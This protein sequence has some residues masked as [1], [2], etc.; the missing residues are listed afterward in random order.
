[1]DA[2]LGLVLDALERLG[3]AENTIVV[4]WGDHGWLLG[5]H[6]CWQKMHLFEEAAQV[7]L[8]IYAP[9]QKA[10]GQETGRVAE[11]LDVYPTLSD[12]CGLKAPKTVQG[13][14]L[15][16]LLDDPNASFK[17]G[18]Y[19]QVLRGD[20]RNLA[21]TAMGRSV[22]TERWRYNEWGVGARYGSELYDHDADPREHKNLANLPGYANVIAEMKAL[23]R[24]G[25]K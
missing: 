7:P 10:P 11:L 16:P 3:L 25:S 22:R 1:M 6:G 2:Q 4:F 21:Q 17:K 8:I 14:S 23:L 20:H 15:R 24:Q 12:L 19:T 9:G 13:Q 18:A 5:E